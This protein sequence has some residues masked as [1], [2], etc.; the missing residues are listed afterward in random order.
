MPTEAERRGDFS[1]S[2]DNNGNLFNLIRD[3]STG[4]SCTGTDARGCF[5]D[6]G[7]VGRI[8]QNR[9]YQTGLNILNLWPLPNASGT[10]YNYE[11]VAPEDKRLQQQ[12][13]I[14][15]DYQVSNKMRVMGKFATQ[16]NTVKVRPGSIPGFN[17]DFQLYP[18]QDTGVTTVDYTISN[19]MFLEA[20]YGFFQN[21]AG[22]GP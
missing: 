2:R 14:R 13:Q 12:I 6:G 22:N 3:A 10:N 5:S 18:F 9:L 4:L 15:A 17:D 21:W 1:Q 8:P 16:R 20:T 7:V 11:A 19:S